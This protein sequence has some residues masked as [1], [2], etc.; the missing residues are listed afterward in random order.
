[1]LSLV[2]ILGQ[3]LMLAV[4]R[5]TVKCVVIVLFNVWG[6][7]EKPLAPVLFV[8]TPSCLFVGVQIHKLK[9]L[10]LLTSV[11]ASAAMSTPTKPNIDFT[12]MTPSPIFKHDST[13]LGII[14]T[15]HT[16]IKPN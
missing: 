9:L 15:P 13:A 2:K 1:M 16:N 10:H 6:L 5:K 4:M 8:L 7:Q 14:K 12:N 11:S 3:S